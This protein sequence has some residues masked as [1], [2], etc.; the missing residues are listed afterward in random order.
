MNVSNRISA[1][2]HVEHDNTVA[3]MKRLKAFLAEHRGG[4]PAA[5]EAGMAEFLSALSAGVTVE[6][7]RHFAFEEDR[8]FH[9]LEANGDGAIGAHLTDEHAVLRLL[10]TQ[11]A[12]LA[13]TAAAHGWGA[14]QWQQFRRLGE[15][16][17]EHLLA[18]VQKE[19]MV[20]LPLLDTA[21]DPQT[22]VRLY[23]DYV[24]V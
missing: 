20:L 3:L 10:G 21:M 2:L 23:Q 7:E 5:G 12:T 19:E 16:Y 18:H 24:D 22:E 9:Y 6:V 17:A 11:L 4:P 15:E 1:T 13:R 14:P 8:L